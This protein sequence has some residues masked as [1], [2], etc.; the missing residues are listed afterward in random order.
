MAL[1]VY[2]VMRHYEQVYVKR[3]T[4]SVSGP[5]ETQ[6]SQFMHY[7]HVWSQASHCPRMTLENLICIV[8]LDLVIF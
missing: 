3:V 6:Q 2:S 8:R 5:Q 1:I 4:Y 7:R